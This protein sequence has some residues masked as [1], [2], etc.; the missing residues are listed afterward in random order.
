MC[1]RARLGPRAALSLLLVSV[2]FVGGLAAAAAIVVRYAATAATTVVT[3]AVVAIG[4]WAGPAVQQAEQMLRQS[5]EVEALVGAP[6]TLDYA[7]TASVKLDA[8]APHADARQVERF[9]LLVRVDG[10]GGSVDA[11]CCFWADGGRATL[12][13]IEIA[14]VGETEPTLLLAP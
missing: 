11:R 14:P 12:D 5:P 13:H 10:P 4:G 3:T 2:A 9:D 7:S 6:V 1:G 8:F